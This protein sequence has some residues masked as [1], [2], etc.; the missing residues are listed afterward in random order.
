LVVKAIKAARNLSPVATGKKDRRGADSVC[1]AGPTKLV[2][3]GG[4]FGLLEL[5]EFLARFSPRSAA[6]HLWRGGGL[7]LQKPQ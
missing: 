7:K 3:G 5:L 1:Y 4:T 6:T 2:V